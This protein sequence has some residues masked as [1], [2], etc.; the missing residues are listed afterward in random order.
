MTFDLRPEVYHADVMSPDN[1][2]APLVYLASVESSWLNGRII[3]AGGGR[4]GLVSNPQIEREVIRDGV[5]TNEDTFR[6]FEQTFRPAV[7]GTS[8]FGG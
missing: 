3:W 1:V 6:E 5:W 7:E 2:V 4:I 8:P